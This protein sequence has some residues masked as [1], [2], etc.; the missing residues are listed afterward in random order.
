MYNCD[1]CPKRSHRRC[2]HLEIRLI[3]MSSNSELYTNRLILRQWCEEDL[4][5]FAQ[6]NADPIVMEYFPSVL[7]Q[8]ES[9]ELANKIQ[10]HFQKN[11]FGFWAVEMPTVTR[12]AGFIGLSIPSFTAHFTPCVE[13]GWRLK[14][15]CWGQGYATEG[16]N[17]CLEFGFQELQ[18]KEI[19]SLTAT[20][21]A[22]SQRVMEKISMTRA[23]KDDFQHPLLPET[24]P[25][26]HHV[27]YRINSTDSHCFWNGFGDRV[28]VL[29]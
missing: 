3:A 1:Q 15:E 23:P 2:E 19:V 9:D 4:A 7:S 26:S 8:K 5:P 28:A 24:H 17:A 25:L 20:Q 18:L 29:R 10:N 6:M 27:L 22:R 13:I 16:A 14:K 12:F 21:N 11:G